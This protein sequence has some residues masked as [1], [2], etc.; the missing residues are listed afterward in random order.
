MISDGI[1]RYM[2]KYKHEHLF[3]CQDEELDFKAII[4]IH[5]GDDKRCPDIDIMCTRQAIVLLY[6]AGILQNV[7]KVEGEDDNLDSFV[8]KKINRRG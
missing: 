8:M 7:P 2:E 3:F 6:I 1:L 5:N 4:A